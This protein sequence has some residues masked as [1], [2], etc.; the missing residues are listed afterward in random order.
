MYLIYINRQFLI[1]ITMAYINKFY[2]E[3][4]TYNKAMITDNK[5]NEVIIYNEYDPTYDY[6]YI[7]GSYFYKGKRLTERRYWDKI[8]SNP[9]AIRFI[10]INLNKINMNV[11]IKYNP[12]A[13][14]ILLLYPKL[15]NFKILEKSKYSEEIYQHFPEKITW[16]AVKHNPKII[17]YIN[18][19]YE[20]INWIL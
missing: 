7:S 4:N 16:T 1:K 15:I 14:M 12:N 20:K 17:K 10:M 5:F 18:K 8:S 11:F 9:K 19:D 13:Y 2:E 3:I 6:D